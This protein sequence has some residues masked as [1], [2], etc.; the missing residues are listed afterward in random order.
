MNSYNYFYIMNH[1]V[2]N[3]II[4]YIQLHLNSPM[5]PYKYYTKRMTIVLVWWR[6]ITNGIIGIN[7]RSIGYDGS[8]SKIRRELRRK[9][10][11]N[12]WKERI[13]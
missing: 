12:D 2:C 4:K 6:T 1:M 9:G 13:I 10:N 5:K 3:K 11:N 8:L 7:F